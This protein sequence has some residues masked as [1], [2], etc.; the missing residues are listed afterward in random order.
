MARFT[1]AYVSLAVVVLMLA[2]PLTVFAENWPERVT[3][4]GFMTAAGQISDQ[5]AAFNGDIE[6]G[7]I[8]KRGSVQGTHIGLNIN[9]KIADRVTMVSQFLSSRVD[10]N[11]GSKI[12]WAFISYKATNSLELRAG[13]IK[14]PAGIVNEYVDVGF[15]YPWVAPPVLFYTEQPAGPQARR[16]AY[17][18]FSGVYRYD[19][20]EVSLEADFF[21]G[22]VLLEQMFVRVLMGVTLRANWDDIVQVQYTNYQGT[23]HT[24]GNGEM[25]ILMNGEKHAAKILGVKVDWNNLLIISE[26]A[27]VTMGAFKMGNSQTWYSTFGYYIGDWLPH[28][29]RQSFQKGIG[30]MSEQDQE[31]TTFGIRYDLTH[32]T[33][34]KLEYSSITTEKGVGL[35]FNDDSAKV[36]NNVS[37]NIISFAVDVVF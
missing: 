22:E 32:S 20:D 31:M 34:I 2:V 14:Y 12:D 3:L 18:G 4:S 8:D 5:N 16:E 24:N 25:D 33:A 30:S 26:I 17:S 7:G 35:F 23:M 29:T 19:I 13:K 9:A 37:A 27:N 1:S 11:F 15:A 28:V 6:E 36:I 21:G 10:D